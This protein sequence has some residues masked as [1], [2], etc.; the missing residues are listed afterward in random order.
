V[1][2][3][4]TLSA[5]CVFAEGAD[6]DEGF[7]LRVVVTGALGH[8][9][10]RL[11]ET[12]RIACPD[13]D[14]VLVDD[15]SARPCG[16]FPDSFHDG[17]SRFVRADVLTA[18]LVEIFCG[19]DTAIHLAAISDASASFANEAEV[20]RINCAGTQRV[21]EACVRTGTAL[22]FVS[23]TSVYGTDGDKAD[24]SSAIAEMRPQSPY[25][26]SKLK[27]ELLLQSMA[28]NAG[29]RHVVCR[30]GT[31]F[32]PSP[33]MKF[34][35]AVSKFCRQAFLG[36]PIPV[37]RTALDQRRP[38]LELGDAVDVL[39]FVVR[40]ALFDGQTFNALTLNA[41]V[42]QII[43]EV[44]VFV[45]TLRTEYVDAPA[46]NKLSFNVEPDR[47]QRLGFEFRG[48]LRQGIEETFDALRYDLRH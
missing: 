40:R 38:Y 3:N 15:M 31:I 2:S 7:H 29:L 36:A 21:A 28:L 4:P 8:I 25:A 33:G 32:G 11:V 48:T 34:H 5:N 35:T 12:F 9:G 20:E 44:S 42:R 13:A 1:G 19:A 22:V 46:M 26:A 23:T 14:V 41:T 27:A 18:D 16:I 17:R 47:L 6:R 30:F 43:D 37:W 10:S 45:P 24:E 39:I